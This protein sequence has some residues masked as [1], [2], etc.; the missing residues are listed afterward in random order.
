MK[1]INIKMKE[2][3]GYI[4]LDTYM[5]PMLHDDGIKLNCGRNAFAY[6]LKAKASKKFIF[7]N[8]CAIQMI[9]F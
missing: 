9:R 6:I 2:I 4:E 8:L 3:G 7:L 5:N 1:G